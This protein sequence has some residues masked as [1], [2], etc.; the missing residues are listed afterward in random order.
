MAEDPA[1]ER[2]E[3]SV[4]TPAGPV[5]VPVDVPAHFVPV[6][7][8]VSSLRRIGEAAQALEVRH[9]AERGTAISCRKGCAAC[10]R[11]LIPLSAP[12]AFALAEVIEA[13][14]AERRE[15]VLARMAEARA[16]LEEAGILLQLSEV[17]ES[18]RQLDDDHFEPINRAYYALRMPCPFLVDEVC[19][20]YDDRPAACRE[21]LV[22]SPAEWCQDMERN[23]VSPVPIPLRIGTVLALLWS[24]LAGGPVRF[25]PLPLA[26]EWAGRHAQEGSR[27]W[28]GRELLERA[29]DKVWWYLSHEVAA[30]Q[31]ASHSP[32]PGGPNPT[33]P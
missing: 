15:A 32:P 24:E 21:L 3:I 30:R 4:Q 22:S 13:W 2:L 11:M 10:C 27:S 26:L 25:I 20:I 33:Q 29:L 6:S 1:I 14:P 23:P 19:S 31:R 18:E 5:M 8:V 9:A 7:S 12:E 28:N 17:A 16:R